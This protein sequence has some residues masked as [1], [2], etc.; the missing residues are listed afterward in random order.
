MAKRNQKSGDLAPAK[1]AEGKDYD[2][3]LTGLSGLLDQARRATA[4]VVNGVMAATYYELGRRI[5]EFEQ[6]GKQR[7]EYGE[8]LVGRLAADL[9]KRYGRGFSRSN[10]FQ[11][12]SFYAGWEI[13][14]TPSGLF[15]VRAKLDEPTSGE[16]VSGVSAPLLTTE[17]FPLPWS[18]YVRLM[19]VSN[20]TA[21][22]F[23]EDEAIKGGWSVRQLD[24]QISTQFYERLSGSKRKGELLAK[25]HVPQPGDTPEASDL[26]RDPYVLEFLNL[27]DEYGESELEEAIVRNLEGFLVELGRGFTFV[28]RQRKIR[29]DAQW[30]KIDLLLFHRRL[31]C[32]VVIDLKIGAFT[33]ADAGQ[34]NLYLNYAKEHLTEPGEHDPVGLILCSEKS[35][36]VVKYAMGGINAKVFASEYLT[37]LPSEEELRVAIERAK[38]ALAAASRPP[39]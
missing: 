12:R 18:H 30:Y 23:Y 39:Q 33:H 4:R 6:G 17:T 14:Q 10:L 5:V 31:R 36:T 21:R 2:G 25:A 1:V 22:Q 28:A 27:T 37:V 26:V 8:E 24:R 19:T 3:L 7:A 15:Q 38:L 9:T 32:L 13:V 20:R 34:M 16:R 35:D 11:I 29:I